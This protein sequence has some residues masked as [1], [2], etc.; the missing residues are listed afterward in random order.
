M[1]PNMGTLT[2]N[3]NDGEVR[4]DEL[5]LSFER[6]FADGFNLYVTHTRLRNRESDYFHNEF[7]PWPT[8]R[9]S[10]DSRPNRLVVTSV[11]E[12]PF[13]RN[14]PLASSGILAALLG[15]FQLGLVYELQCGALLDFANLFH[16][17]D[18]KDIPVQE[19]TFSQW[20]STAGFER[21]AS[22]APASYHRRV[23]PTRVRDVRAEITNNWNGSIQGAAEIADLGA[24]VPGILEFNL[25]RPGCRRGAALRFRID[26]WLRILA[27]LGLPVVLAEA[28]RLGPF[29]HAA[30]HSIAAGTGI[31]FS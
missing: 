5:Q 31:P 10:N 12:L 18:L 13:G 9:D 3:G 4:T 1:F 26:A 17:G 20:F 27:H 6:R 19:K 23:F 2:R 30:S 24:W 15:G 8:W 28:D 16:Y 11:F 25:V 22:R 7:D 21:S 29:C 14:K